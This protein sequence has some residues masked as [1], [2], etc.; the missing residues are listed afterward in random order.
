MLGGGGIRLLIWELSSLQLYAF[1]AINFLLSVVFAVLY[2]FGHA[3]F[4]FSL[5]F[6]VLKNFLLGPFSLTYG[7]LRSMLFSF[8]M[9][10]SFSAIFLLLISNFTPFG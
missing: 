5:Q 7:L 9:L 2:T 3:A 4:L 8:Q 6:G 10:G 1:S